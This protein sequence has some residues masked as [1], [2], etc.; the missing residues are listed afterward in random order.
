MPLS[1]KMDFKK[2]QSVFFFFMIT[3][4][5]IAVL[6]IFRPFF[7]PMFWAAVIAIMFYPVYLFLERFIKSPKLSS[8]ITVLLV[9]A[10]VFLPLF[11]IGILLINE[12]ASLYDKLTQTELFG[13]VQNFT[14][15]LSTLPIVG[16]YLDKAGLQGSAYAT[17]AAKSVSLFL[18]TNLK[19][20]TQ[21]SIR[22]FLLFFVMIYTLFFFLK[23]GKRM[24]TKLMHLC[25][26]GD[27]YEAMLYQR[28]TSTAR[29]TLKGTIIIGLVQGTLGG[30]LFALTGIEGALV[31]GVLMILLSL[32]PGIGSALIWFPAG[33][34]MLAL[35][36]IWQGVTILAVGMLVIS[37]I[38]NLMRPA[39][40][41]KDTQMHP[42]LILFST[43]GGI[44]F[45]GISGFVI[46][47]VLTALFLAVISIYEHYYKKELQDN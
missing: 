8:L 35:G 43:L 44:A 22:F 16:P 7:Y 46:G 32:I 42:I 23:D 28:F 18:F 27:V 5:S 6:Y 19:E 29:A 39:L 1:N 3:V 33:I 47:P 9:V 36:N 24:L 10:V 25:P 15:N 21:N 14:T 45:F 17:T 31:W 37:M 12:S 30:I 26:L 40:V 34:I 11:G 38:D 41:G 13:N 2:V 4:F 20:V